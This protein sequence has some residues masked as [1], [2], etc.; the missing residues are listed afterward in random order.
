MRV[1]ELVEKLSQLDQELD[2]LCSTENSDLSPKGHMFR[3][4]E[5]GS[6]G[7][8]EA[9]GQRDDDQV[10]SVKF[11]K[12]AHSVK[13]P[14]IEVISDNKGVRITINSSGSCFPAP[15]NSGLRRTKEIAC[16]L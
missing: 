13:L 16:L 3:F 15:L 1:E 10:P 12:S 14:I 5:I 4:L 6:V 2:V 7:A 11:G 8:S 9:E